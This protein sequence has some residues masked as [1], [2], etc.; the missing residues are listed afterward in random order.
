VRLRDA[1]SL[2]ARQLNAAKAEL[3]QAHGLDRAA[4]SAAASAGRP[5]PET[6]V[7]AAATEAVEVAQRRLEAARQNSRDAM[8]EL[9]R[10]IDKHRGVWLVEQEGVEA[11]LQSDPRE[12]LAA[13]TEQFDALTREERVLATLGE[14]PEQGTLHGVNFGRPG[15]LG[16]RAQANA[17]AEVTKRVASVQGNITRTMIPRETPYLLAELRRLIEE[18]LTSAT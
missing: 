5:L 6:R 12:T 11:T 13:L 15:R 7:A 3:K 14:F 2:A 17:A 16:E 4:D 10:G 9:V 18:A 1:A 8:F